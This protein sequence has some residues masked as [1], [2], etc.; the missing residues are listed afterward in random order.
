LEGEAVFKLY[1]TYGFPLDLV[2]DAAREEGLEVDHAG[3]QQ[4]LAEQRERAR[5]TAK[6]TQSASRGELTAALEQFPLTRFV[7]YTSQRTGGTLLGMVKNEQ[8][9]Q[10][11]GQGETVEFIL[12]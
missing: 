1:D 4:A 12:D 6:F 5:K 7:G 3:Y 8:L 10:E 9:I 2:E 11:A